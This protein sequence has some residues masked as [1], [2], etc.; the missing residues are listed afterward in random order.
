MPEL[1][2][3]SAFSWRSPT[4]VG[5]VASAVVTPMAVP[6]ISPALPAMRTALGI[7]DA[8][9]GLLVTVY[10][11]PGVVLA[12][13][14]GLL[15]DRV[16]RRDVLAGSLVGFGLFG[17]LIALTSDFTIVLLL[18]F[19]QGCTAGSVVFSLAVTLVGDHFE[20]AD[21]NAVM[22]VA[23]AGLSLGVAVYPVIGGYL[24]SF[25]WRVPFALY[26]LSAVVGVFVRLTLVEPN[27]ERQPWALSYLRRAHA[28][29]PTREATALYGVVLVREVL[30]FGAVFTALP[31]LLEG[32]F[33]LEA[34]GIGAL[35]SAALLLTAVVAAV[36]G[37]LAERVSDWRLLSA[38]FGGYA[39]GLV[40]VGSAP[41]A[42]V[43]LVGLAAFGV[44]HGVASPSLFAALTDLAP[45]R[46]RAG[47]VALRTSL[48]AVGQAVGPVAFTAPAPLVGYD[49]LLVAG[50]IAAAVVGVAILG[51]DR[52]TDPG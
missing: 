9:A 7:T 19:L 45:G 31:F 36:N 24:S 44:G 13:F 5:I 2:R 37:R 21:R 43:A 17:S 27:I 28:A 20:G 16:G 51:V 46:F 49:G 52:R 47:V 50:G 8:Q 3:D 26:A 6:L 33:G 48:T 22:G 40:A 11:L 23:T 32:S 42:S 14:A 41:T 12:P 35:T 38:G 25:G 29:V 15:A 34:T 10:A 30:L 18:R 4:V 39:V 1:G